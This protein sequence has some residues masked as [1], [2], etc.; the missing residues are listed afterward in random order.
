MPKN[1]RKEEAGSQIKCFEAIHE[2]KVSLETLDY[3]ISM[4]ECTGEQAIKRLRT[5]INKNMSKVD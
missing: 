1:S 4:G 3:K 2:M 5:I